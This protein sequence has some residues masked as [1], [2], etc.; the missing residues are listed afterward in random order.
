M[1]SELSG[2]GLEVMTVP[3]RLGF[4]W[5]P[6]KVSNP[7]TD[8]PGTGNPTSSNISS[9]FFFFQIVLTSLVLNGDISL[10]NCQKVS[11]STKVQRAEALLSPTA[12][13]V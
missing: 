10:S 5:V 11:W 12:F 1:I 2:E 9:F 8:I 4:L 13:K 6:G 7:T 3:F